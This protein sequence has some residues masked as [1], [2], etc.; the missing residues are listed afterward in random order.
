MKSV[1]V[2]LRGGVGIAEKDFVFHDKNIKKTKT[3]ITFHLL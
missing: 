3:F 2:R 1:L